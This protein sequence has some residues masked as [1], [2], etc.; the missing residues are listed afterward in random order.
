MP[1][2]L[3][4]SDFRSSTMNSTVPKL[5]RLNHRVNKKKRNKFNIHSGLFLKVASSQKV[6][7]LWSHC[8]QQVLRRKFPAHNSKIFIQKFSLRRVIRHLLLAIGPKSKFFLR[9]NHLYIMYSTPTFSKLGLKPPFKNILGYLQS[10]KS[11][12]IIFNIQL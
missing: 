9:L 4:R 1:L 12:D 10:E 6:F 8:Q 5:N 2:G 11:E 7:W 3:E